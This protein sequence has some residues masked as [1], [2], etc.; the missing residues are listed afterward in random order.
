[1]TLD[2][3]KAHVQQSV[4]AISVPLYEGVTAGIAA[5]DTRLA[6]MPNLHN[7]TALTSMHARYAMRNYWLEAGL[8]DGWIVGGNPRLM[9]QT[10]IRN[11]VEN[12]ELRLLKE[13]RRTY[14]GG[15]P[16]A[17]Y[18]SARRGY[19]RQAPLG[20]SI[21]DQV[22]SEHTRLL[23]LWDRAVIEGEARVTVRVVHTRAPGH[24]G[25]AV[26]IDMSF[27]VEPGGGLFD[28]LAFRGDDQLDDFFPDISREDNGDG[29]EG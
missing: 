6:G 8:G 14:P 3:A 2:E 16:V 10:I 23:L 28:Q 21:P 25:T 11:E 17:G 29:T 27:N 19:W 5:A 20:L 18:N 1:M 12:L 26:P 24:F 13:R 22:A 4:A 9:G 7:Y 15:A